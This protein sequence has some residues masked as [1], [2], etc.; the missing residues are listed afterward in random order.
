MVRSRTNFTIAPGDKL[1]PSL[2]RWGHEMLMNMLKA[3]KAELEGYY[4][5]HCN[6]DDRP[7]KK[8]QDCPAGEKER[9]K[10]KVP[11]PNPSL[12]RVPGP[13]QS[14][15]DSYAEA[16]RQ[17]YIFWQKVTLGVVI[18]GGVLTGGALFGGAAAGGAAGA[19]ARL[20]PA[21]AW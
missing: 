21:F 11:N 19:G 1:K 5:A 14:E 10:K 2:S 18:V 12:Q 20:L 16:A 6:D 4:A 8:P 9:E 15:L 17:K 7:K 3:K 13:S